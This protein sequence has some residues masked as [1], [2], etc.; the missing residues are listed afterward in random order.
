MKRRDG[1]VGGRVRLL[2]CEGWNWRRNDRTLDGIVIDWA[3]P[4]LPRVLSMPGRHFDVFSVGE[5]KLSCPL[6][7]GAISNWNMPACLPAYLQDDRE[8]TTSARQRLTL[9][10]SLPPPRILIVQFFHKLYMSGWNLWCELHWYCTD[11]VLY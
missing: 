4:Y 10:L 11:L 6:S 1:Q 9:S 7:T 3:A 5:Q 8:I 2:P